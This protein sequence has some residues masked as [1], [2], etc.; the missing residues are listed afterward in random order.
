MFQHL[1]KYIAFFLFSI[2]LG[3]TQEANKLFLKTL[4]QCI[5]VPMH[6][7]THLRKSLSKRTQEAPDPLSLSMLHKQCP[8]NM[9]Q[10]D[11]VKHNPM[12]HTHLIVVRDV[13]NVSLGESN[14]EGQC[15]RV[16]PTRVLC[17]VPKGVVACSVACSTAT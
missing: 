5:Y 13:H 1:C 10:V 9:G 14:S 15:S 17:N 16:A 2:G 11:M 12:A 6:A 3:N 8:V 7:R 4:L